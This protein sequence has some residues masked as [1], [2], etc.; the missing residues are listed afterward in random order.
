M[1]HSHHDFQK[2]G[3]GGASCC[4]PAKPGRPD[5]LLWGSLIGIILPVVAAFFWQNPELETFRDSTIEFLGEMWW[6]I[7]IGVVTVGALGLVPRG[8][9]ESL[10]TA[11]DG[12]K[13]IPRAL[14]A[15]V[16]LDMCNHGIILIGMKL[17]ERGASLGQTFAFLIASP[18]NSFSLTL[19]LFSL[20]GVKW[21]LMFILFS[22]AIGYIS[23]HLVDRFVARGVLPKHPNYDPNALAKDFRTE[24]RAFTEQTKWADWNP[25][26][27]F[28]SGLKDS[29]MII[30]WML[31]GIVLASLIRTFVPEDFFRE[32]L[33][34]SMMGLAVTLLFATIMEVC[35][36]GSVPIAADILSR[37]G[38]IGN[39]FA[40]L[41]AGASTDYTEIVALRE[42]T[43]SWKAGL[44]LPLVTLPQILL[45]A[46]L[47]NRFAN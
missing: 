41:M 31:L 15:G 33:G 5:Y 22:L 11:K 14:M 38:A 30:R 39:G 16:L 3:H 2:E 18:W 20:I 47:L 28:L 44:F 35:S 34:P 43:G 4:H 21:T 12:T 29:K 40:F 27:L 36:E 9:I 23:G 7:A 17:Y 6:G 13:S 1:Q 46:Y 37:A 19:I 32:W 42:A 26:K 10:L 25:L 24:W 8:V 45:L